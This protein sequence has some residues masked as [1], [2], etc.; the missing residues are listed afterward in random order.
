MSNTG[1]RI[2]KQEVK[3]VIAYIDK[4]LDGAWNGKEA[5]L[6]DIGV[7]SPYR[8]QCSLITDELR[9]KNYESI[10]VGTAEFFQGMEKKI[11]I[12]STVCSDDRLGFVK[13]ERVRVYW[14]D[15][16]IFKTI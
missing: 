15:I 1:S 3:T 8:Q 14:N 16:I 5:H 11:M 12:I 13:D 9:R 6:C 4:I 7:V 10:S 2:N